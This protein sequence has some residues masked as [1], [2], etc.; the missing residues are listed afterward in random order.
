MKYK[1]LELNPRGRDICFFDLETT[2]LTAYAEIIEIGALRVE[3]DNFNLMAEFNMKLSPTRLSMAD[4]KALE[5]AGYDPQVW[6]EEAVAPKKGLQAFMDFASGTVLSAHNLPMDWMWLQR[7]L[8]DHG[9][10]P[11]YLYGGIDTMSLAWIK[12]REHGIQS[13]LSLKA[14]ADYFNI[15][16]G[17]PHRALDDA[18]TAYKLFVKL[19][20]LDEKK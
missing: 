15:D 7:N 13:R 9:L 4:P 3:T 18:R 6:G 16:A 8:E 20:A 14:L 1:Y 10:H 17:Q 11:E 5:V 12:L 19:I 2:G